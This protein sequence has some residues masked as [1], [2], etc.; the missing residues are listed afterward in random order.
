MARGSKNTKKEEANYKEFEFDGKEFKYSGRLYPDNKKE[1]KKCDIIPFSLCLNGVI[2]IKGMKL[3]RTDKNSWIAGPS[4]KSG[5][6]YKD[7]LYF[8]KD[9]K[10]IDKLVEALEKI[11][12]EE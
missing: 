3:W 10:E 1:T 11:L 7:Y 6:D 5:D 2:T 4:Y 9:F 12:D 8:D